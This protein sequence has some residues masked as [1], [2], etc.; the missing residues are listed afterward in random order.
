MGLETIALATMAAAAATGAYSTYQGGET[1]K[2]AARAQKEAADKL[3]GDAAKSQAEQDKNREQALMLIQKRRGVV[4]TGDA[5][6]RDTILTGPL[7]VVNAPNTGSK[8]LL[9]A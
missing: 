4:G 7:G 6:P 8:T 9:G 3:A 2:K 5:P 1:A